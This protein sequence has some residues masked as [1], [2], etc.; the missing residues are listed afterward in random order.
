VAAFAFF[1]DED[2]RDVRDW[3]FSDEHKRGQS[4][5]TTI[6]RHARDYGYAAA[7]RADDSVK[8]FWLD[9][10]GRLRQKTYATSLTR[11]S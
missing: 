4:V 8:V 7:R 10:R 5:W 1:R 9:E 11:I 2:C 6:K 3:S